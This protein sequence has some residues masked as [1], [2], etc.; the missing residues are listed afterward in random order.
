MTIS[1]LIAIGT[2]VLANS[3]VRAFDG[4]SILESKPEDRTRLFG[5]MIGT[6]TRSVLRS[7]IEFRL[8]LQSL[9]LVDASEEFVGRA[10]NPSRLL[11]EPLNAPMTQGA[12]STYFMAYQYD[13]E[14]IEQELNDLNLL[15]LQDLK[16]VLGVEVDSLLSRKRPPKSVATKTGAMVRKALEE[17]HTRSSKPPELS[18]P[19]G[20]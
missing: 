12:P 9:T 11:A 6:F 8:G 18:P 17:A 3:E 10:T 13:W 20:S 4:L 7:D 19:R 2:E 15:A 1:K 14:K 16:S 5:S